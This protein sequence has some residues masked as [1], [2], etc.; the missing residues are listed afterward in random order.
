MF[1]NF[2]FN[3][4]NDHRQILGKELDYLENR[5]NLTEQTI[6]PEKNKLIN[7]KMIQL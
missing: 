5:Q 2:F 3:H 1:T 4:L 6:N 7:G